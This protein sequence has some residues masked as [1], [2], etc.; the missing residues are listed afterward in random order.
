[1]FE[2]NV[3]QMNAIAGGRGAPSGSQT[4]KLNHSFM[5]VE[6][7]CADYCDDDYDDEYLDEDS[8][9]TDEN[10]GGGDNGGGSDS[11]GDETNDDQTQSVEVIGNSMTDEEKAE[12]DR[13]QQELNEAR[14]R[15]IE[16]QLEIIRM[17]LELA[18]L[19][20]EEKARKAVEEEKRKDYEDTKKACED[21]MHKGGETAVRALIS[22]NKAAEWVA[23]QAGRLQ[24]ALT[25]ASC[26]K[27]KQLNEAKG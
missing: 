25:D 24:A 22:D 13:Q 20:E 1:M 11:G 2:L 10:G 15:A 16:L 18:R 8:M 5:R 9:P 17:E 26:G 23:Y 12:Y 4:K 19:R 3:S 14:L 6:S 21:A 7:G 27:L